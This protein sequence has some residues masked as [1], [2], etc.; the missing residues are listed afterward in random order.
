LA[1]ATAIQLA[2]IWGPVAVATTAAALLLLATRAVRLVAGAALRR[3]RLRG[4]TLGTLDRMTG[5]EFEDWV[6]VSLRHQ[7]FRCQALPRT[8][9]YGVD[10]IAERSSRRVGVQVKRYDGP[11]GN[12]AVQQAIAG[13]GHHGCGIA[14]VVTQ[15]R[16]TAAARA[17]A[18]SA[19]LPV[20]LVDREGLGELA[21]LLRRVARAQPRSK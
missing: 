3:W 7:G 17:Q 2:G 13:A 20:V 12:G 9:D 10:V 1:L 14:A 6:V 5:A 19:S 18:A 4:F 15:S 8:R 16:F 21:W 11:V